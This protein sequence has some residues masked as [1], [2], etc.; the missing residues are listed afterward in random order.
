MEGNYEKILKKPNVDWTFPRIV[1]FFEKICHEKSFVIR[2]IG[3][4]TYDLSQY[5]IRKGEY[6]EAMEKKLRDVIEKF[7]EARDEITEYPEYEV[8][9]VSPILKLYEGGDDLIEVYQELLVEDYRPPTDSIYRIYHHL[10]A[11]CQFYSFGFPSTIDLVLKLD[12][13]CMK[14]LTIVNNVIH[15]GDSSIKITKLSVRTVRQNDNKSS[16][17]KNAILNE[18]KSLEFKWIEGRKTNPIKTRDG[19]NIS[20]KQ[21]AESIVRRYNSSQHAHKLPAADDK[22]R[23]VRNYLEKLKDEGTIKTTIIGKN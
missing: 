13:V 20:V 4:D 14:L 9:Y 19:I 5:F 22:Y 1:E 2:E 23:L 8:D 12:I 11:L 6:V 18:W 21:A 16:T 15:T 3:D 7:A 10:F 17:N